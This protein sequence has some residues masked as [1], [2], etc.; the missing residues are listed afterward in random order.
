MFPGGNRDAAQ[1]PSL[2]VTAI[3]ETFEEAGLLLASGS[4]PSDEVLDAARHAIHSGKTP[5]QTFLTQHGLT[6][7][8]QALLPFTQWITPVSAPR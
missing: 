5:F 4:A 1:D 3:R 7:D 8:V 6:A 2:A